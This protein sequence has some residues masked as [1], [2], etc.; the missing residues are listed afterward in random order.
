MT[1]YSLHKKISVVKIIQKCMCNLNKNKEEN[2]LIEWI[3][4]S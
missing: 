4:R 3:L 2:V 1:H